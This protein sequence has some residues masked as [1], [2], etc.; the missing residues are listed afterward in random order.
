MIAHLTTHRVDPN[1]KMGEITEEDVKLMRAHTK[2]LFTAFHS[3][4][5]DE[6][7]KEFVNPLARKFVRY[8]TLK[9][10]VIP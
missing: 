10:T 6:R 3:E 9:P 8:E 2:D 7:R 5:T 1:Y 4:L